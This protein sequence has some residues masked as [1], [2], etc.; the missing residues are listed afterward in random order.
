MKD[1]LEKIKQTIYDLSVKNKAIFALLFGSYARGTA[2]EHS[3]LDIIFVEETNKPFLSRL[4]PYFSPLS[5]LMNGGVD[6]FVYTPDEFKKMKKKFFIQRA[7]KEG[8]VIF[9]SRKL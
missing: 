9:E 6:V 4:D 1:K 8:V 7:L 3:D 5:D 2:T